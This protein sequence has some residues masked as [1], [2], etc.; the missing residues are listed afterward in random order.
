MIV[1]D[2]LGL[3][4][5]F[6]PKFVRRYANVSGVLLEAFTQYRTDVKERAFPQPEHIYS[7]VA[8]EAEKLRE[9]YREAATRAS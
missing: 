4:E 8:G 3:F 6:V 9:A 1:H 7:M 2:M 5:R